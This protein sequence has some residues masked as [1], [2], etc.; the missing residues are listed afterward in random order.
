[1]PSFGTA[2]CLVGRLVTD[3]FC[4]FFPVSLRVTTHAALTNLLTSIEQ[5]I[6]LDKVR[7]FQASLS[8]FKCATVLLSTA[9]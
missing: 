3:V 6:T 8:P 5:R 7:M 9:T 2:P 1:M 4:A